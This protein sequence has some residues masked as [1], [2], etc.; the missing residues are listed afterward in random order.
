MDKETALDILSKIETDAYKR[1]DIV[2]LL[3]L[4]LMKKTIN[5]WNHKE[6]K[7]YNLQNLGKIKK[8]SLDNLY[9][10]R[11]DIEKLFCSD[12]CRNFNRD[13]LP[14]AR[15]KLR[16]IEKRIK[17]DLAKGLGIKKKYLFGKK[18]N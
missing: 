4:S 12:T 7:E 11:Y 1:K 14:L 10:A 3:A 18:K 15:R 5:N 6:R 9:N 2:E 17:K 16:K 8:L 13:A